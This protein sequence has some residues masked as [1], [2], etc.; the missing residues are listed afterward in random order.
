VIPLGADDPQELSVVEKQEDG[1][2]RTTPVLPVRFT[3]LE[4]A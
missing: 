3:R 2:L 4:T 1:T